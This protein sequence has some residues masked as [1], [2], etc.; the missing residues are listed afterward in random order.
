[1][2]VELNVCFTHET[3]ADTITWQDN[4]AKPT[5]YDSCCRL[6][7]TKFPDIFIYE[8]FLFKDFSTQKAIQKS[9][10]V[11]AFSMIVSKFKSRFKWKTRD[12]KKSSFLFF[13]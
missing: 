12:M 6:N 5:K 3:K 2:D 8:I 11:S 10:S 1:M 4:L 7:E 13:L 9:G